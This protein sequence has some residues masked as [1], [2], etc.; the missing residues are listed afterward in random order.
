MIA[1][2]HGTA[3]AAPSLVDAA[4][5]FRERSEAAV[6]GRLG[7]LLTDRVARL[8]GDGDAAMPPADL[9]DAERV[10]LDVAEQFVVDVHG[11]TDAGFARLREHL[12]DGE[13]VA[14]MFHLACLD[15]FGKLDT[16]TASD[17]ADSDADPSEDRP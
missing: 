2:T 13:I 10:V 5:S 15:G 17:R 12:D 16:V 9:T 4:A 14:I 3:G 8:H 6:P 7:Q 1:A 11:L